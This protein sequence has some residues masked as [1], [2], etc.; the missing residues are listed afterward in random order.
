MHHTQLE[1]IA[2]KSDD[3]RALERVIQH[4]NSSSSLN[5]T[6]LTRILRGEL[7][8]Q[9]EYENLVIREALVR[10]DRTRPEDIDEISKLRDPY[11]YV[12]VSLIRREDLLISTINR[13]AK[14]AVGQQLGDIEDAFPNEVTINRICRETLNHP[15]SNEETYQILSQ[16]PNETIADIA[17]IKLEK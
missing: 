14:L 5:H 7:G 1:I 11:G 8:H 6:I 15:N 3:Y 12:S 2:I 13:F 17:R 10:S 16:S 9:D 4:N